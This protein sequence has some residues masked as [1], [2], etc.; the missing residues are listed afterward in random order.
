MNTQ[1][2]VKL[3]Q[4]T[5]LIKQA[6]ND[7]LEPLWDEWTENKSYPSNQ[8]LDDLYHA[9]EALENATNRLERTR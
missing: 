9:F 1:H 6:L 3:D 7:H 5:R 2:T 4:A 8:A